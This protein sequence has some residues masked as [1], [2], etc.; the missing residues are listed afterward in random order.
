MKSIKEYMIKS[1]NESLFDSEDDLLDK[2][3][4]TEALKWFA[5]PDNA[6]GFWDIDNNKLHKYFKIND[7]G[8][9]SL[10]RTYGDIIRLY[11]PIPNWIQLDKKSWD[12]NLF[13]DI[14]YPIKTQKDIPNHGIIRQIENNKTLHNISLNLSSKYN[15]MYTFKAYNIDSIKNLN[16][17]FLPNTP[18]PNIITF[19][20]SKLDFK[21]LSDI[22]LKDPNM[23]LEIFFINDSGPMFKFLKE[24]CKRLGRKHFNTIEITEHVDDFKKMYIHGLRYFY[25]NTVDLLELTEYEGKINIIY[26]KASTIGSATQLRQIKSIV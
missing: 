19:V 6:S 9:I 17:E 23:T 25:I 5:D 11:K 8:E 20:D 10:D 2:K 16:I 21:D 4:S 24:I 18:G 12:E 14:E 3:P 26:K 13:I 7:S 22:Y 15:A 1:F